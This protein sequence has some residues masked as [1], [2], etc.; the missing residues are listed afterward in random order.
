[1]HLLPHKEF[2][3]KYNNLTVFRVVE[4][5]TSPNIARSYPPECAETI[6]IARARGRTSLEI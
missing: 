2:S 5:N 4:T 6:K 1:M 3:N